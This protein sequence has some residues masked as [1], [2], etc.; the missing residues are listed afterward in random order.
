MRPHTKAKLKKWSL[1]AGCTLSAALLFHQIQASPAFAVAKK[2]AAAGTNDSK[3]VASQDQVMKEFDQHQQGQARSQGR[4]RGRGSRNFAG[5]SGSTQG[6]Q[7]SGSSRSITP[8]SPDVSAPSGSTQT[9][10]R[11]TTRHS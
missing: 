10:P 8:S 11:A 2:E 9:Q 1:G 6:G 7:S 5:E 4:Q 3:A